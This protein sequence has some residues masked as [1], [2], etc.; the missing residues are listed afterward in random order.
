MRPLSRVVSVAGSFWLTLH[1]APPCRC[2][3]GQ[4]PDCRTGS[5]LAP[6]LEIHKM[7]TALGRAVLLANR[8]VGKLTGACYLGLRTE[9]RSHA[10]WSA[11]SNCGAG[12]PRSS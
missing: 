12:D 8:A 6:I 7:A 3:R 4:R 2:P 1:D 11:D 10:S 9:G 5:F